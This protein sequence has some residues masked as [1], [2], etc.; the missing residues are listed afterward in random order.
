MKNLWAML[1][2]FVGIDRRSVVKLELPMIENPEL[3]LRILRYIAQDD[4]P[5]PANLTYEKLLEEFPDEKPGAV[6]CSVILAYKAN[7]LMGSGVHRT[8]YKSKAEA[9]FRIGLIDGLSPEGTFYVGN[10]KTQFD[11]ACELA[12]HMGWDL[13]SVAISQAMTHLWEAALKKISEGG[14]GLG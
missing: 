3:T 9:Q 14:G 8:D 7:L 13:T 6:A 1:T 11:K 4:V 12:K 10:A 5:F 2:E